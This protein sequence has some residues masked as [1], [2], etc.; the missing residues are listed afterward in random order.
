MTEL[1]RNPRVMKKAQVEIR[2]AWFKKGKVTKA[3]IDQLQYLKIV[4]KNVEHRTLIL[5]S[6]ETNSRKLTNAHTSLKTTL[7]KEELLEKA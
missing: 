1:A 2:S 7:F 4:E 3:H 5:L 6:L